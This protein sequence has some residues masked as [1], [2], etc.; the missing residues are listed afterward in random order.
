M[1][2]ADFSS[3]LTEL[4]LER[5]EESGRRIN[6]INLFQQIINSIL[7][8]Y[9]NGEA[10]TLQADIRFVPLLIEY[11]FI[12]GGLIM[13][14]I[15]VRYRLISKQI[16][17]RGWFNILAQ[18]LQMGSI[19][20]IFLLITLIRVRITPFVTDQMWSHANV[21]PP[22]V[23]AFLFRSCIELISYSMEGKFVKDR[24]K[25]P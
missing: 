24:I 8:L 2:N 11:I 17:P 18:M 15:F 3:E 23:I 14:E 25:K 10:E 1:A 12:I 20:Y 16:E 7:L 9:A 4:L 6:W 19:Y 5:R 22:L 13:L 21:I